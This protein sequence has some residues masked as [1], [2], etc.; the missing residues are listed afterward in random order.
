MPGFLYP[1]HP[2]VVL[3]T[4]NLSGQTTRII[5]FVFGALMFL[6]GA[7]TLLTATYVEFITR[8][9]WYCSKLDRELFPGR[10]GVHVRH[11]WN[12]RSFVLE[13]D[14]LLFAVFAWK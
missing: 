14:L 8:N 4:V 6:N 3:S 10:Y 13:W 11:I 5:L 9:F 12:R 2:A 7:L 1:S